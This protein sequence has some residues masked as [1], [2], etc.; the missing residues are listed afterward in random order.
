MS[1]LMPV[2][3]RFAPR[4]DAGDFSAGA[5]LHGERVADGATDPLGKETGGGLP[6]S[7][8]VR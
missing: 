7:G 2:S 1:H 6:G 5:G 4:M 8:L 3:A